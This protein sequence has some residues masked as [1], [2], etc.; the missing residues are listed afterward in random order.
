MSPCLFIEKRKLILINEKKYIKE[1]IRNQI[2]KT[3][4][5]QKL[6]S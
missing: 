5:E 1:L 6:E 4:C 2:V 3:R